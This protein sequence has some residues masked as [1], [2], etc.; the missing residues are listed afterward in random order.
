[1]TIKHHLENLR[2]V[3]DR[4]RCYNLKL[5]PSKCKFFQR[6][7]T[8]LG[9]KI[10]DKGIYPD[11]SKFDTIKNYP[12][13]KNADDVRR[14]VAFC[15]YY[16]K[17]IRSFAEIANPLNN[18]LKKGSMFCWSKE[19]QYAFDTLRRNLAS[20]NILQYPDFEK[21]FIITTDASDVACGAI[22]S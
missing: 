9:H 6:S 11:E 13:P 21:E 3:F 16:R 4:L 1:M 5:N 7:V 8:Y 2:K 18:L 20:P 15:N 12:L 22:L 19:C 14:F 17:F 10:T